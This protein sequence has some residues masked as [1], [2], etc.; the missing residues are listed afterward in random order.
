MACAVT[1]YRLLAYGFMTYIV[2]VPLSYGLYSD[3]L[4]AYG[5]HRYDVLPDLCTCAHAC[6]CIR[7]CMPGRAWRPHKRQ[8]LPADTHAHMHMRKPARPLAQSVGELG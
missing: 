6:A 8:L 1:A 2:T 3:G 5:L 4:Y 7:A